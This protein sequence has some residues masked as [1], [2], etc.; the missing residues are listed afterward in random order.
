VPGGENYADVAK[1]AESWASELRADTFAVSHGAFTRILRGLFAGMNGQQMS[2][3]DEEQGVLFRVRDSV[4]TKLQFCV[5]QALDLPPQSGTTTSG[6][7][8]TR[9]RARSS[10]IPLIGP[11]TSRNDMKNH[12]FLVGTILF[13]RR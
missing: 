11:E 8:F 10:F 4:V 12:S 9:A 1:R 5:R 13:R 3:L 7:V 2:A 6:P